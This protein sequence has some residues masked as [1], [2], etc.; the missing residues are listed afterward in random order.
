MRTLKSVEL[1][2]SKIKHR[3]PC[4]I[5]KGVQLA[6]R[7]NRLTSTSTEGS[8]RRSNAGRKHFSAG[9]DDALKFFEF[10]FS[11]PNGHHVGYESLPWK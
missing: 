3:F 6:R 10:E 1:L 8:D 9:N 7:E 2:Y 4:H 5:A 11:L